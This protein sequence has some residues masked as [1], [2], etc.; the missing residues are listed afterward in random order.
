[1]PRSPLIVDDFDAAEA[2]VEDGRDEQ[3]DK[4]AL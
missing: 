4:P 2:A 3:P 1:M